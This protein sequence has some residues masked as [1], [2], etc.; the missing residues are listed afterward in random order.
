MKEGDK[1]VRSERKGGGE[2]E[3]GEREKR[4]GEERGGLVVWLSQ[5]WIFLPYPQIQNTRI[6]VFTRSNMILLQILI[7]LMIS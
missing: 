7:N 1:E 6:R 2:R 4:E 3:R 5:Y